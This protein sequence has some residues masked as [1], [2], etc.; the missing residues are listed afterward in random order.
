MN[1]RIQ[2]MFIIVAIIIASIGI[3]FVFLTKQL[4]SKYQLLKKMEQEKLLMLVKAD[5]L[6]HSSDDLTKYARLYVDTKEK[7]Y[8]ENYLKIIDIR[9]GKVKRP[10]R[11]EHIYWDLLEPKRSRLH[12]LGE[13]TSLK[14]EIALLPY[15]KYER[16]QLRR[17]EKY[18][19]DLVSLEI[20]AFHALEGVFKDEK[21]KYTLYNKPNQTMAV[22]MLHSE[23]YLQF[24]EKVM[25]PIDY[26][27]MFLDERNK[28]IKDEVEIEIENIFYLIYVV[29]IISLLMT[30]LIFIVVYKKVLRPLKDLTKEVKD[31]EQGKE[32]IP[33]PHYKDEMGTLIKEFQRMQVM[34]NE[35]YKDMQNLALTDTLTNMHNKH[36]I[37]E[38]FSKEIHR[39]HRHGTALCVLMYDI[40]FFKKVNDT[41]GH[42]IGDEILSEL[43]RVAKEDLRSE[44]SIG[45][46]GGE[47][48]IILLPDTALEKATAFAQRLRKK[49][50]EHSFKG[51]DVVTISIGLIEVQKNESVDEAFKRVDT[52]LYESKENGRNCVS[53]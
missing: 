19:N 46:Y 53:Y 23:K 32:F 33:I 12:P 30:L 3:S 51:V 45:R 40:D 38:L 37:M 34:Q 16:K 43:S 50:E 27:L 28:Q 9:N 20:E 4:N 29:S 31:F 17:A 25:E 15:S 36:S 11:Y 1:I 7:R 21:G 47:E 52:L 24:K 49:V 8:K 22:E 48:F 10:N 18:S 41:F 5:E 35:S 2:N 13:K 42:D 39:V 6:R 26:F 44:D 14:A